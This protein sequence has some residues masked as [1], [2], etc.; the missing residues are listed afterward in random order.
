MLV[1]IPAVD[2]SVEDTQVEDGPVVDALED[3][4]A[5]A[6]NLV[7]ADKDMGMGTA[8]DAQVLF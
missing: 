2:T 4:P 8:V 3:I 1:D 6:G 5:V 7:V